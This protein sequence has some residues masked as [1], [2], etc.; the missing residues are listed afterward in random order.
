M[1]RL[2]RRKGTDRVRRGCSEFNA[3]RSTRG[4]RRFGWCGWYGGGGCSGGESGRG[5]CSQVEL[6]FDAKSLSVAFCMFCF[7]VHPRGA[8]EAFCWT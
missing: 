6:A 4:F 8:L 1:V 7:T 2:T 5:G 3:G